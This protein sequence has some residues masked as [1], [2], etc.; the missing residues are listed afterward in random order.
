MHNWLC[1][2]VPHSINNIRGFIKTIEKIDFTD[3]KASP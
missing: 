1:C 3:K 2:K